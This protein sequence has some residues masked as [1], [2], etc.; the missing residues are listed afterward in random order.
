LSARPEPRP[1][2]N[3]NNLANMVSLL[4]KLDFRIRGEKGE[5]GGIIISAELIL[6]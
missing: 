3:I 4:T 2:N 1:N 6:N 5:G